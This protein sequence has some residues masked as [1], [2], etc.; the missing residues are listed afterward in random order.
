MS[1]AGSGPLGLH[2][3]VGGA[4]V[5]ASALVLAWSGLTSGDGSYFGFAALLVLISV[6]LFLRQ[7]WARYAVFAFAAAS[8]VWWCVVAWTSWGEDGEPVL[9]SIIQLVPG[10]IWCAFW[11]SLCLTVQ[12]GFA[13]SP[14]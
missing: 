9:M 12:R 1:A 3:K 5:M 8:V 10:I 4:L 11:L 7:G 2:L 6:G 14:A 13:R